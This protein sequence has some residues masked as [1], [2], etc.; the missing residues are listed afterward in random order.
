MDKKNSVNAEMDKAKKQKRRGDN[1]KLKAG[2]ACLCLFLFMIIAMLL[3]SING[4]MISIAVVSHLTGMVLL[5]LSGK[6]R[7]LHN[8]HTAQP[9]DWASQYSRNPLD[10]TNPFYRSRHRSH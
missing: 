6:A 4:I 2:I 5:F 7:P 1:K 3:T 10:P 8:F 9:T